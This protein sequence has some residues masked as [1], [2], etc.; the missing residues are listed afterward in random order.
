ME[1]LGPVE[2]VTHMAQEFLPHMSM[3]HISKEVVEAEQRFISEQLKANEKKVRMLQEEE[4]DRLF[5][6]GAMYTGGKIRRPAEPYEFGDSQQQQRRT[7]LRARLEQM[8]T[9]A[10]A[11]QKQQIERG[12]AFL[13]NRASTNMKNTI[14]TMDES[15]DPKELPSMSKQIESMLNTSARDLDTS[16]DPFIKNVTRYGILG[17][18]DPKNAEYDRPLDPK[19]AA[20]KE[21]INYA[22]QTDLDDPQLWSRDQLRGLW[23]DLVDPDNTGDRMMHLQFASYEEFFLTVKD[24]VGADA[25][26]KEIEAE[27]L[28]RVKAV[29]PHFTEG[30]VKALIYRILESLFFSALPPTRTQQQKQDYTIDHNDLVI[31]S[32]TD[33]ITDGG[34]KFS[35]FKFSELAGQPLPKIAAVYDSIEALAKNKIKEKQWYAVA[36]NMLKD[37]PRAASNM[38]LALYDSLRPIHDPQDLGSTEK[39]LGKVYEPEIING[40]ATGVGK[41]KSSIAIVK[42]TPGNGRFVINGRDY[43]QYFANPLHKIKVSIPLKMVNAISHFDINVKVTGG[44]TTGQVDAISLGLARALAKFVPEY[45]YMFAKHG[46]MRRDPREVERKKPG[47]R[48]ARRA[49]QWVKR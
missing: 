13:N 29:F 19:W 43:L 21:F 25:T 17:D 3:D 27:L 4:Q 9:I 28:R 34:T 10:A 31:Q 45:G 14:F 5:G 37:D 49:F 7:I 16:S 11:Q 48:K 22:R 23:V 1:S 46:L 36:E 38:L 2:R 47:R 41:R 33:E 15:G 12:S 30:T 24:M 8:N 26:Q 20:I 40:V 18:S 44:G 39:V 6:L 42:I 35:Y 32:I